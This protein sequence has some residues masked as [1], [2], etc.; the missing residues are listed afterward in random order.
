MRKLFPSPI[1]YHDLKDVT[2][3]GVDS[4]LYDNFSSLAKKLGFTTGDFFNQLIQ[5]KQSPYD[6]PLHRCRKRPHTTDKPVEVIKNIPELVIKKKDLEEVQN[7]YYFVFSNVDH[8]TFEKD[9]SAELINNTVLVIRKCKKVEFKG[10][11]PKLLRY[12]IVRY[13]DPYHYPVESETIKDITIRNVSK[14]LYEYLASESKTNNKNMGEY[15]SEQLYYYLPHFE[16]SSFFLHMELRNPLFITQHEELKIV[17]SDLQ[18]V[19]GRDII[20]FRVKN[21][22]FD[23]SISQELFLNSVKLIA[24]C[25]KV[26]VPKSVPRL[27]ALA[28]IEDSLDIEIVE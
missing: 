28:R 23:S 10:N 25:T 17:E 21:L 6:S 12:G 9:V 27:I 4:K 3:R 22:K 20:F 7:K 8:L 11:I 18:A 1:K 24:K 13:R 19:Q 14:S 5:Y 2:I 15:F 16:I 26:V